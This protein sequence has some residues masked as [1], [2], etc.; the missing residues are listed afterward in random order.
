[1][2]L[3]TTNR[4]NISKL[5]YKK[6]IMDLTSQMLEIGKEIHQ[7]V[8]AFVQ[9]NKGDDKNLYCDAILKLN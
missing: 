1:M 9:A 3:H 5:G 2:I 4:G 8:S 6:N 7:K